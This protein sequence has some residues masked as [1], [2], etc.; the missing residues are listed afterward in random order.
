MKKEQIIIAFLCILLLVV[1]ALWI[2]PYYQ[3]YKADNT[4]NN[5]ANYDGSEESKPT[6]ENHEPVS[7]KNIESNA[8]AQ[9]IYSSDEVY[10]ESNVGSENLIFLSNDD[11][12]SLQESIRSIELTFNEYLSMEAKAQDF[13]FILHLKNKNIEIYIGKDSIFVEDGHGYAGYDVQEETMISLE[14]QL[15]QTYLEY[16][17]QYLKAL[18]LEDIKVEALDVKQLY[19]AKE[20]DVDNI[21]DKIHF[22]D[23]IDNNTMINIPAEYPYYQIVLKTKTGEIILSLVNEDSILVN[24][25]GE[26]AYFKYDTELKEL[27]TSYF[28]WDDQMKENIYNKI[29]EAKS[30]AIEDSDIEW[31]MEENSYECLQMIRALINANKEQVLKIMPDQ[32][33]RVKLQFKFENNQDELLIFDD[34]IQHGEDIYKSP[35]IGEKLAELLNIAAINEEINSED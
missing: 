28:N 35:L 11:K 34:Y 7:K 22:V 27:I 6:I 10:L 8:I 33:L 23:I 2:Y 30:I 24:L 15:N 32:S 14:N 13:K 25:L 31:T 1:T 21:M 19:L 29:F 4:D 12:T 17:K 9:L 5:V 3:Q 26:D 16:L 20:S 18:E